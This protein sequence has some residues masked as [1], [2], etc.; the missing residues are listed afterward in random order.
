VDAWRALFTQ[1]KFVSDGM[2]PNELPPVECTKP[3]K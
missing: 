1:A 2:S 3:Q